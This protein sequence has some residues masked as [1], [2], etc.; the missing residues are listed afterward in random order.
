MA[1][2]SYNNHRRPRSMG[3]CGRLS[4][5]GIAGIGGGVGRDGARQSDAARRMPVAHAVARPILIAAALAVA[6]SLSCAIGAPPVAWATGGDGAAGGAGGAALPPTHVAVPAGAVLGPGSAA[7][8]LAPGMAAANSTHMFVVDAGNGS[9][10]GRVLAF[11]IG[12]GPAGTPLPGQIIEVPGTPHGIAVNGT[13][14]LFV[15]D[16]ASGRVAV[17]APGGGRAGELAVPEDAVR[18]RGAGG[19]G[20]MDWPAGVAAAPDGRVY[21]AER[22]AGRVLVFGGD[23]GYLGSLPRPE[24]ALRL[25]AP[26]GVAAGAASGEVYVADAAADAVYVFGSGGA[27]VRTVGVPPLDG[28]R[29]GPHGVAVDPRTGVLHVASLLQ[30]T[31]HSYGASG[32]P[33][34]GPAALVPPRQGGEAAPAAQ[35]RPL[36]VA[37]RGDGL[38]LVADAASGR[39]VLAHPNGTVHSTVAG[40]AAAGAAPFAPVDAAAAGGGGGAYVADAGAGT[41]SAYGP[42]PPSGSRPHLWTH[43]GPVQG[44]AGIALDADAGRV[45]VAHRGGPNGGIA[46]GAISTVDGSSIG[47]LYENSSGR[48]AGIGTGPSGAVAVADP[49]AGAVRLLAAD[50][51]G[52]GEI[53]GLDD[54]ADAAFMSDGSV[55]VAERGAHAV[56]IFGAGS[57]EVG[58]AGRPAVTVAAFGLGA[59]GVFMPEAVAVDGGDR[60]VVADAGGGSAFGP[61]M[62]V[63]DYAGMFVSQFDRDGSGGGIDGAAP[64][65][66]HGVPY[67]APYGLGAAP[68][69]P[70]LV[71]GGGAVRAFAPLDSSAP[72]VESF[73]LLPGDTAAPMPP[74]GGMRLLGPYSAI[75]ANVTFTEPVAVRTP[76]R[77]PGGALR[78]C[79]PSWPSASRAAAPARRSH[80]TSFAGRAAARPRTGRDREPP[81]C[82]FRT[83]SCPASRRRRSA[84]RR[85]APSIRAALR[86]RTLPAT[87]RRC[88]CRPRRAAPAA[89]GQAASP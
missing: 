32:E 28:A 45:L 30:G 2:K 76:A 51:A 66:L 68:G 5:G 37:V 61:R 7:P 53:S 22:N 15:S 49:S 29:G 1:C 39:V 60:I 14:H 69:G 24:S 79:R 8:V 85:S 48:P 67:G 42:A 64:A 21:V 26:H 41:V 75:T 81:R 54:P 84:M 13:G 35:P 10:G 16:P 86:L 6:A 55:V 46:V 70:V 72:A 17:L 18:V 59:G 65:R 47:R 62:Q 73:G 44:P 88:R 74:G 9:G 4:R 23:G 43:G 50:G 58:A 80:P 57:W 34:G 11:E 31:L 56:R 40:R 52:L 77:G 63:F 83:R 82:S 12:A 25:L 89:P 20:T 27:H 38:L 71:A 87:G 33:D 3:R 19:A 78:A 36:S